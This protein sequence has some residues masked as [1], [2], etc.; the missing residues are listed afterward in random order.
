MSSNLLRMVLAGTTALGLL[1]TPALAQTPIGD[2]APVTDE[3]LANP[4]AGDWLAYGRAVDNYRFSP[5]DQ[6]SDENVGQLQMVWSRGMEPGPVQVSPIV[7]DGIMFLANAGDVIQALDAVSGDLIWQYRRR[8]P[9]TTTLHSL[10]D[11][12][13]GISIYG[14]HLYF[15]SWDNHLVA[16]DMKTGQLAWEIDRGQG[17]EQVTNTSGPIVA[18]GVIIAGSSCQY[19]AFGCFI[20]GHDAETGEELWRNTFIPRPGEEGDETW[21]NDYEARWM[22]GVWGQITYDPELDLVYYGSSAVG[23]ASETQRG[24]PGGTLYGTNTRF[25][26]RPATGEIVWRHQTLPRDNW[27]QEC[28][29]EMITATTDVNPSADMDGL[30]A[31]GANASGEARRVLTGA[32]CKTATMW[33]F[34]AETGEFLWARDT[35]YQNMIESIDDQG[36]VTINEDTVLTEI[37]VA[38]EHCPSFLGGRD[39]PP[40]AFNPNTGIYFLPL[41]NSCQVSTARDNEPTALDVYNVDSQYKLPEG[42]TDAGR[43]DAIDIATGETVWSWSQP[44]A[45][46]SP[47]MT[48]AGNLLFTGGG[49]RYLK[50]F[51][52][53]TGDLLWRSRLGADASGHAVTYE[54]D[55]RQYVAIPA[56]PAGFSRNLMPAGLDIDQGASSG[57]IYVFALPEQ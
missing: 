18:N 35:A 45:Q 46:Y 17:D 52:A 49:D 40:S 51:N 25:A 32:P 31:I 5:L 48:T 11:R 37:G 54:V 1:A 2:L 12:K 28:T 22:T 3:M 55:G 41:N 14:D 4:A 21:G 15:V 26:V 56:G 23:P 33:Q 47:V 34:D 10:G 30:L 19:S 39:W 42:V 44:A 16:L 13:R 7:Y 36:V 50:A 53:E 8:L 9:D 6:I 20:S 43:I 27:D 29:F 24:T 38:Y 57:A